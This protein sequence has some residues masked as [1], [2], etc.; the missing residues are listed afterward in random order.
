MITAIVIAYAAV[1]VVSSTSSR[2]AIVA[3]PELLL[4]RRAQLRQPLLLLLELSLKFPE[5]L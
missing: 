5:L 2:A 3:T 4:E 1:D